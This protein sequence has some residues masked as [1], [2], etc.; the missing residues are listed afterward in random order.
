MKGEHR[1]A[2]M[3]KF[4][5][6]MKKAA[7]FCFNPHL[8]LCFGIAW[9]ITN[10][11]CYLFIALG[12]ALHITWMTVAGTSWAFLLWLP[13]TPEKILTLFI[14]IFL[15]RLLFP[16]D[17]KTLRVLR[18]ELAHVRLKLHVWNQNRRARRR[19]KWLAKELARRRIQK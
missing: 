13:F 14:A 10:G 9:F 16:G 17:E 3:Q 8:L 5:R 4:A 7:W 18:E 12:S 1:S 2:W 15:L 6:M 19:A 11:W